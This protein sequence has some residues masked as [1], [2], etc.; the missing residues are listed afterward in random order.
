MYY[1]IYF[2]ESNKIDQLDVEYSYYGAYGST[3]I[4]MAKVKS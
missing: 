1:L 2:D 4:S 3:D